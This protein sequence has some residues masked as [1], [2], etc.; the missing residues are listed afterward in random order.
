M[1]TDLLTQLEAFG[2]LLDQTVPPVTVEDFARTTTPTD[3]LL[4]DEAEVLELRTQDVAKADRRWS[5]RLVGIAA[6]TLLIG[7]LLG[8][9]LGMRHALEPDHLAAVSTLATE[10]KNARAGLVIG[11]F[12]GI[13]HSFTLLVVG[14]SKFLEGAWISVLVIP[15]LVYL[16]IQVRRHYRHVAEQ[17]TLRGLPPSL[18]PLPQPRVVVSV[19]AVHRGMIDAINFSQSISNYVTAVFVDVDP[20]PD[21]EALQRQ[22]NAWFPEVP[23]VIIPSPYRSVVEPLLSYLEQTDIEHHDGQQAVLILPDLIPASS[24]HEILHNQSAEEIK[25]ALLYQRRHSGLQRIIIDVPY[26]LKK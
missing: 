4:D 11:A 14:I 10:H 24:W 1:P 18:R 21:E 16:F 15:G 5:P 17:L 3:S 8:V 13:G 2:R 9:A 22:W 23:L 20:G 25:N 7:G 12:W 6:A 26:H 19:S